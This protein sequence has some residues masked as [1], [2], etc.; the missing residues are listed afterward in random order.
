MFARV[1]VDVVCVLMV[2]GRLIV[3]D[4]VVREVVVDKV[5]V[6]VVFLMLCCC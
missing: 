5:V 4:V 2:A 1:V 6:D 3:V